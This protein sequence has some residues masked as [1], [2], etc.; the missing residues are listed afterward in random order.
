MPT[1]KT[2]SGAAVVLPVPARLASQL[3]LPGGEPADDLHVTLAYLGEAETLGRDVRAAL[4]TELAAL[5]KDRVRLDV[6]LGGVG[7]FSGETEDALYLSVDAPALHDL[8]AAV[9]AACERAG[10]IVDATHGYTPHLTLAY[11]AHD[12]ATPYDRAEPMRVTLERLGLWLGNERSAWP[13]ARA[14]SEQLAARAMVVTLDALA[15]PE[16]FPPTEIK[17]F[18]RGMNHTTKGDFLL[19]DEALASVLA[20]FKDH[21]VEL[22]IDFDHGTYA[23]PGSKRD[24]AGWIGALEA[25]DDGLYA[26]RVRW[27]EKGLAA[28]APGT[29]P[30][31]TPT[32]PEYRYHSPAI[33][34][35]AD[36]RRITCVEPLALVTFPA[37]KG[38][39]PLVM[40]AHT[41]TAR[42]SARTETHAMTTKHRTA[43]LSSLK[44]AATASDEELFVAASRAQECLSECADALA[45]LV[46]MLGVTAPTT[47]AMTADPDALGEAK[48]EAMAALSKLLDEG[49][50]AGTLEARLASL[51]AAVEKTERDALV[52]KGRAE[53]KLNAPLEALYAKKSVEDLRDFLSAAPRIVPVGSEKPPVDAARGGRTYAQLSN[54]ERASLAA[55]DP[56][57]FNRLRTEWL[58]SDERASRLARG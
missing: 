3:A 57:L 46:A 31:G 30:D 10:A 48:K 6:T 14:K 52:A 11:L 13:L 38:Q 39:R 56:A 53:G 45:Q 8:R 17:L 54:V 29:A 44:L 5:A 25:R 26:T 35:D 24:T 16:V 20:A 22:A 9:L 4:R 50:K 32:P 12:D 43:L 21:D 28:I 27:T 55:E 37:S 18:A 42:D 15:L 1:T 7:R 19:D 51:T 58:Q 40:T 36:T 23:E 49:R 34:F 41:T 33:Q 2:H 47:E